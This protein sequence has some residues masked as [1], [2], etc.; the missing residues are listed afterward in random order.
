MST[1]SAA[2]TVL[3]ALELARAGRFDEVAE[4]FAAPLRPLVTP[5]ALRSG[6]EAELRPHGPVNSVG[7]PVTEAT[8]TGVV[9]VKIL[10]GCEHGS[11]G[12]VAAV[13]EQGQLSALQLTAPEATRPIAPWQP[14][15]YA[16]SDRFEEH[17]V[18][19]GQGA[20]AVPGTLS[21]PRATG[22]HPGV[23]LL[24]GSGPL[25][26]DETIGRNK[27]F[28]DVAWGLATRGTA[29]LRFEKVTHAHG[30]EVRRI[31]GFTITDEYLTDALAAVELLRDHPGLDPGRVFLLGHSLGGTVAPR[32]AAAEATVAG[33]ILMAGGAQP[34]HWALVRQVRYLASLN[35]ETEPQ[36][37]PVIEELTAKARLVDSPELS[38]STPAGQLPLGVGAAY[39]LDLRGYDPALTAAGLGKPILILQGGRDYQ[40]TVD[41]DLARWRA[42]LGDRPEVT[43][44]V[45]PAHNH[46]FTPGSGPLTPAEY[47][48]AQHVDGAVIGDIADWIEQRRQM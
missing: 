23:V 7:T 38:P 39:W 22:P 17:E 37:R 19:L 48:P 36:S 9:V 20:L 8:G 14:P 26:R 43:V 33:L 46:M 12:V 5:D 10:L 40:V 32:I 31:P 27:P 25:D 28:K 45:Y 34:L 11:V 6:W 13:N 21:L 30:G 4:L 42:A 35:P 15:D 18:T 1:A 24:A 3:T 41:D 44:R 29:V 2:Q 16:D 47:E